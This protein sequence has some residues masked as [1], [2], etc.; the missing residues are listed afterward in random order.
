MRAGFIL[1]CC[2]FSS[3]VTAQNKEVLVVHSYHHGFFWT[4]RFQQGLNEILTTTDIQPQIDYLDTK[5]LQNQ[6]YLDQ[7]YRLYQ[8]QFNHKAYDAIVVSDNTALALMKQL[9]PELN[10]T[11]VI[12]GGINHYQADMH[13]GINATGVIEEIDIAAN[14]ELIQ[15]LQNNTHT[16]YLVTDKTVTGEKI[17]EQINRYLSQHKS[18]PFVVKPL[19]LDSFDEV[20]ALAKQFDKR[21]SLILA[22]FFREQTGTIITPRDIQEL[23]LLSGGPVYMVHDLGL[24][25]GAVGGVM[26]NARS[27][28]QQAAMKLIEVLEHPERPLPAIEVGLREVK[29]D[30]KALIAWKLNGNDLL[31]AALINKPLSFSERYY[32]ELRAAALLFCILLTVIVVLIYYLSRLRKSE[33]L[34]SDNQALIEMVFDQSYQLIGL[35]DLN[36]Y[37]LSANSKLSALLYSNGALSEQP[38]W[39]YRQWHRDTAPLIQ[40]YFENLTSKSVCQ[41]EAELFHPEQGAMSI[42]LTLRIL[43]VQKHASPRVLL[44]ARDITTRKLTEARLFENEA[45]LSYYYHQQPVMMITLDEQNRIQ[46]VNSFAEQLLGYHEKQLLGHQLKE[47]YFDDEALIARQILL[48]PKQALKGVWRR[49]VAYRHQDGHVLWIRENIR[50][51]AE[52]GHLLIAGEDVTETHQLAEQLAYQAQYD[53]LTDTYNRNQFE[54]ELAKALKEVASHTRTHAM[55]Y[56]DVDQ[57]KVLNDTAGHEAG[58]AAIQFCA[59]MLQEVLPSKAILARMGGDEFA[60]LVKDCAEVNVKRVAESILMALAQQ[61]FIWDEI[62]LNLTCSIGIRLIDHSV[63]SPQM[64]HAQADTAC[65]AAKEEGRNRYN[66]YCQDDQL[67]RRREME[68]SCVNLVHRALAEDCVELFAQQILSLDEGASGMHF[69][70]LVRIRDSYGEYLSPGLFMPASERYSIAHLLDKRVIHQTLTW[71]ESNPNALERLGCC[72]INISGQ[73]MGNQGFVSY[74]LEALSHT[75]VPCEKICLEIT[76][77]AAMSNM[78]QAIELFSQLKQLG[79]VIALD[80]FGSGLS[81]FGYLKKLPVDIVKID[82]LFVRDMANNGMDYLM[83]KSINDLAQK[84][85]KRTVAEFVENNQIIDLLVELGVDYAQGYVIGKP[86]PLADLVSQLMADNA[87]RSSE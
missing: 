85:G 86:Q 58:D 69:E 50:P 66:I 28:G 79:C 15:R 18:L 46:Q 70:V 45:T 59:S 72:A 11:P 56:L 16:V 17:L 80:D 40:Q 34:A 35:L 38:L 6:D 68:M 21:T 23:S 77:T 78:N 29:L 65:H 24:G 51:L 5:R 63:S 81:S 22:A 48:Q 2:L 41:F 8:S 37:L 36:G 75:S 84:M 1:L 62:K 33:R 32:R 20:L 19:A 54:I 57:L 47:F 60:I 53:L 12:F 7:L 64:V 61:P 14:L 25:F 31:S 74:L 73:S 43:S 67:L 83:V 27:Q 87:N 4:D 82:G 13:A 26:P 39:A 49:E 42:E 55:L 71:L 76:E 3:Y 9:A 30:Y 10:G 52:S 44:E